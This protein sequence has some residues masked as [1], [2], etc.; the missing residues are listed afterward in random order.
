MNPSTDLA[1]VT[2]CH[3]YGAY[4]EEWATSILAQTIRP[5]LIGIVEH[6]STDDSPA[7]VD[8]AAAVLRAGGLEVRVEHHAEKL[9]FGIAR[10]RAVALSEGCSWVQ[11]LD[12]DDMLMPHCLADVALLAP[13]CDV[14]ALG[15]E[16]CG[17]LKAGPHQRRKLYRS[18][19]GAAILINTTPASG[20]SPFRRSFWE[21]SPYPE[22]QIGGWDTALW[23]GFA[24]LGARILPTTRPGFWYR[25]HADSVFN[26]RRKQSWPTAVCGNEL[27]SRR[28]KDHGV[29]VLVPR[30]LEDDPHRQRAWEYVRARY[31]KFRPDWE[32]VEGVATAKPWS[33]GAALEA[34]LLK[35]RGKVAI[36]AD[37]DCLVDL[38][39]LDEAIRLIESGA[40]PWVVPHLTVYRLDQ[41][42]TARQL[43]QPPAPGVPTIPA[44]E[45]LARR[46]YTGFAGGG[47]FVISRPRLQATGGIPKQ[48]LG[49]GGEDEALAV[50]FDALLGTHR[51]LTSPLIH[52]WHPPQPD[53]KA[54]YTGNRVELARIRSLGRD[55]EALWRYL[56]DP[57]TLPRRAP[58]TLESGPAVWRRQAWRD[59]AAAF[60]QELE[61][62]GAQRGANPERTRIR[63]ARTMRKMEQKPAANKM[64]AGPGENKATVRLGSPATASLQFATAAAA[65]LAERNGLTPEE[66]RPM[67]AP[68]APIP[69][70][71]VRRAMLAKR[72]AAVAPRQARFAKQALEDC[73]C[74][75][76]AAARSPSIPAADPAGPVIPDVE[77]TPEPPEH[78]HRSPS[79]LEEEVEEALE[80]SVEK[81]G[82][83]QPARR[84][85]RAGDFYRREEDGA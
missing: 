36:V 30:G 20:V 64:L 31:Q 17:D 67:V 54:A 61:A 78:P 19:Q 70:E 8:A 5:R 62:V 24:H 28:R 44:G 79:P 23:L 58:A 48:F 80:E 4:I 50:I 76:Q 34:A 6:G 83:E 21:R 85:A 73:G 81:E 47:V 25:Q 11:H 74:G 45:Q 69:L 42:A 14:V 39:V 7:L 75:K 49:W 57:R 53:K 13:K 43:D 37:A 71:V 35:C 41:A 3:N 2:N 55:P 32:I 51:R 68:G 82:I 10:N 26:T 9:P 46:P 72:A 59:R 27:N 56:M 63:E 38:G 16:R 65:H 77:P 52:C 84:A 40:A 12:C 15:Y 18:S 33:K 29:S 66:L 60:R 1:I 22:H